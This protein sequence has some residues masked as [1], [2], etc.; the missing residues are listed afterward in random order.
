MTPEQAKKWLDQIV[1][2]E[3]FPC[4]PPDGSQGFGMF[5]DPTSYKA[6]ESLGTPL[7]TATSETAKRIGHLEQLIYPPHRVLGWRDFL[8]DFNATKDVFVWI[9]MDDRQDVGYM[10]AYRSG[11]EIYVSDLAFLP[12]Y[13][14]TDFVQDTLEAFK[15][16]C[17][18]G[19]TIYAECNR[20]SKNVAK[21]F[22]DAVEVVD[23]R[24][25]FD[26]DLNESITEVCYKKK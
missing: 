8:D 23:E 20:H 12:E 16:W 7:F 24:E 6:T 3:L 17:R 18:M 22:E 26:P 21:R 13:R 1:E 14:K 25:E 10:V 5:G 4:V 15:Q 2:A 19:D 11:N 9:A